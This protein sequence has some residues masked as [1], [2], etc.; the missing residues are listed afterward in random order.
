MTAYD[1]SRV[2]VSAFWTALLLIGVCLVLIAAPWFYG[3]VSFRD[4][5]IAEIFISALFLLSLG[6]SRSLAGGFSGS[7][8]ARIFPIMDVW[9]AGVFLLGIFYV[10]VSTVRYTSLFAFLKLANAIFFYFAARQAI[11]SKGAFRTLLWLGLLIGTAYAV[12]GLLQYYGYIPHAYWLKRTNLSSRYVNGGHF[13]VLLLFGIFSAIILGV[14]QKRFWVRALILP[15]LFALCWALMLTRSR[16]VWG[17]F[18]LSLFVYLIS[19]RSG[20]SIPSKIVSLIFV[21]LGIIAGGAILG[22]IGV[23]ASAWQRIEAVWKSGFFSLFHRWHF[24]E[25][26]VKA[27]MD[28]PLGWGIGTFS[29][30]FPQFRVHSDR[31]FVDYAHNEFLQIAV[32]FGIPGLIFFVAFL[33]FYFKRALSAIRN[34]QLSDSSRGA[35]AAFSALMLSLLISSLADFGLRIYAT[36]LIF[37]AYLAVGEYIFE[38]TAVEPLPS[39]LSSRFQ[40][41]V[42]AKGIFFVKMSAFLFA[43]LSGL[44]AARQLYAEIHFERG[45][46]LEKDFSWGL[47]QEEYQK[48]ASISPITYEYFETLG[49]FYQ[50]REGLS[51]GRDKKGSFRRE[52][53]RAFERGTILQPYSA[54]SHYALAV[55]YERGGDIQTSRSHYEKA[56]RFYPQ[57][58]VYTSEFAY[59]CLRHGDLPKAIELFESF[60]RIRF[61][62]QARD[63][64]CQILSEVARHTK[65]YQDLIRVISPRWED[66]QCLAK[67]MGDSGKWDKADA[68][69]ETAA[70]GLRQLSGYRAYMTYLGDNTAQFYKAHG[71]W[72]KALKI[73]QQAV[74]ELP[75]Q[76][77]YQEKAKEI[78]EAMD[79]FRSGLPQ[80]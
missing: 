53:I 56:V 51:F 4:Q 7:P 55:L 35:I 25:G 69:F 73:Y 66:H 61:K 45:T 43:L 47:A 48:A 64:P 9:M 15:F 71:Q 28:R 38:A 76:A 75:G 30:V 23:L 58:A 3:L 17:A 12:Y 40:P 54:P 22:K 18:A 1:R 74:H 24:W 77:F 29:A 32:D 72:Q 63:E 44:W 36:S 19:L 10:I 78:S 8:P 62:E 39:G 14:V 34:S 37:A 68:E 49:N 59:F 57:N 20:E 21:F 16:T 31:F 13:A 26:S 41:M 46:K 42:G 67:I 6:V 79:T 50:K 27:L 52:A 2:N 65:K 70:A 60:R 33:F 5:L 80:P 11:G